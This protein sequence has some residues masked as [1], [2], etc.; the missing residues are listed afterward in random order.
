VHLADFVDLASELEDPLRRRGLAGIDVRED[1]DVSLF[2]QVVHEV[3][4]AMIR[5][6]IGR[7]SLPTIATAWRKSAAGRATS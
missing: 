1:A 7:L 6:L 3:A 2:G 4:F 5:P